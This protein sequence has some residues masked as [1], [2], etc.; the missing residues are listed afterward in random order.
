[1]S[2]A[3]HSLSE[4]VRGLLDDAIAAY[5]GTRHEQALRSVAGRLDEPL[6]VAIAGRV[7]AGKSTLLNALVGERVAATDAGECTR[8]VTWYSDGFAY[9]AWAHPRDGAPVQ[10]PFRRVDGTTRIDL[11]RFQ[12]E[13]LDRLR[14][15]F[16]SSQLRRLTLIDTP[17]VASLST[18]ISARTHQ[19]LTGDPGE[20]GADAVVYLMRHLHASDTHFLEAFH[21]TALGGTMPVNAI[22]VLSRA[23]E[24]GAGTTDGIE[25][26][27]QIAQQYRR[28]PRV[29]ALVQT[30]V[31]VAGL[32]AQ[33]AGT[34]R[35]REFAALHA[36]GQAP[37][38]LTAP[39]LLSADRFAGGNAAPVSA[40]QRS[41]LLAR[42]GL[43]G[44]RLSMSLIQRQLVSSATELAHELL[45]RSGLPELRAVLLSQFT[46]R[47]AVLKAHGA[48]RAVDAALASDPVPSAGELRTRQEQIAASA[49]DFAE[50]RLLNELRTGVLDLDEERREAMEVLL[51]ASGGS[52]RARLRLPPDA[53]ADRLQQALAA[54]LGRWQRL[55]ENPLADQRLKRAARVLK[56]T[57]EGLFL[58]RELESAR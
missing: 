58:D 51:G 28:D 27:R 46:E 40:Q 17:G 31:P 57:C 8:V 24:I 15:E 33:T 54:E 37:A 10:V 19:L 44:V 39:L 45:Q 14:V 53:D 25:L 50:L 6:R 32:L 23:D 18:S 9:R 13:D 48:L 29:R 42:L 34:L 22:G 43:F 41:E 47:Q 30:M 52:I 5:R 7:K 49:H 55:A 3:G 12:A 21:D 35:E 16:P 26:A 38:S 36:L 4:L 1:M 20:D 2:P 11:G 56:R